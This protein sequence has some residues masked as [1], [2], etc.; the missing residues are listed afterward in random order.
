PDRDNWLV[1]KEWYDKAVDAVDNKGKSLG[2]VNPVVFYSKPAMSL[3]NY[4]ETIAEEGAHR[5][6]MRTA[7]KRA[8]EE[9]DRYGQHPI[10]HSTGMVLILGE[11]DRLQKEVDSW[12]AKLEDLLPGT[13]AA[14]A[15]HRREAL[16]EAEIEAMETPLAKRTQEQL[17]LSY[18]AERSLAVSDA[19]LAQRIIEL[20][21]EKEEDALLL[22]HELDKA[23]RRWRYT[24][25]Y[26]ETANYAYWENR[27]E[28]EKTDAALTAREKTYQGIQAYEESDLRE[29]K[30]L[31][32]EALAKWREVLDQFPAVME[33]I[34][35]G[36]DLIEVIKKYRRVLDQDGKTLDENFPLWDVLEENDRSGDFQDELNQ[37]RARQKT[38]T[39]PQP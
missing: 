19:E 24:S 34:K 38:D 9:W 22:A 11:V 39:A 37:H 29:A 23:R 5:D 25:N 28:Y 4:A 27:A 35:T 32:E 16:S 18:N 8:G 36:D 30:Q 12:S 1:S 6:K 13:R 20:A 15:A 17:E 31:F 26:R 33:D 21:P 3:M 14:M 2:N 7:W 10:L